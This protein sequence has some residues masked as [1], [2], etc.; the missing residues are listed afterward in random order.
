M[1]TASSGE[2][3]RIKALLS[4]VVE[5]L[6]PRGLVG[7]WAYVAAGIAAGATAAAAWLIDN[8]MTEWALARST[9]QATSQMELV[10]ASR[11]QPLDFEPPHLPGK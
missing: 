1:V 3:S 7:R 11:T 5:T 9:A 6:R 8:R 2:S 10:L 4:H